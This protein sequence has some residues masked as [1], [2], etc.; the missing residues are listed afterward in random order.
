MTIIGGS[1][2]STSSGFKYIRFYILNPDEVEIK[3]P[4][5]I[6]IRIKNNETSKLDEYIDMPEVET[7][8]ITANKILK[9]PSRIHSYWE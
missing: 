1:L 4:P 7:D 9:I 2:I 3:D 6:V 8:E 5:I